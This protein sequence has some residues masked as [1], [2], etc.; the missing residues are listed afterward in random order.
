MFSI[1]FSG[2]MFMFK[3]NIN[4]F[5]ACVQAVSR[6]HDQPLGE[7]AVLQMSLNIPG[8]LLPLFLFQRRR[9]GQP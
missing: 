1:T 9:T 4:T 5:H 3:G 8:L 7:L 2:R 6:V